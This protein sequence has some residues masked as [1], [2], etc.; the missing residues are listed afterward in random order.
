MKN[1]LLMAAMLL[2]GMLLG[3]GLV[4]TTSPALADDACRP[5]GAGCTVMDGQN[6]EPSNDLCCS[7][8]CNWSNENQKYQCD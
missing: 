3:L 8:H 5:S 6:P 1:G 4:G 2:V 7:Q